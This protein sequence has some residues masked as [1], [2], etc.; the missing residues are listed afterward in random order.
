MRQLA[1]VATV[2]AGGAWQGRQ[3]AQTV[4]RLQCW[5]LAVAIAVAVAATHL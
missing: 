5:Q 1:T 2:A 3:S 4:K